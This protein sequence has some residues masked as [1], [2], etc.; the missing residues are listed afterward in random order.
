[1]WTGLALC[2]ERPC[3][4]QQP[5]DAP[6][7]L[8]DAHDTPS[9]I[10]PSAHCNVEQGPWVTHLQG[11]EDPRLRRQSPDESDQS[12]PTQIKGIDSVELLKVRLYLCPESDDGWDSKG[13]FAEGTPS[14]ASSPSAGINPYSL[15]SQA[16]ISWRSGHRRPRSKSIR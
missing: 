2:G 15:N 10:D 8:I 1:M 11:E 4:C 5:L 12:S 6:H 9:M 13:G 16:T 7:E 14:S 3:Q